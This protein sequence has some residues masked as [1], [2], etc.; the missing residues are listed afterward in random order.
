MDS[1]VLPRADYDKLKRASST[2]NELLLAYDM[3]VWMEDNGDLPEGF[4]PLSFAIAFVGKGA[5]RLG[6]G[7][8]EIDF[9]GR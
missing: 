6:A 8:L 7:I 2:L 1:K 3:G 9:D 5:R 4:T